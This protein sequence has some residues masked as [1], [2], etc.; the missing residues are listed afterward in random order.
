MK[1]GTNLLIVLIIQ[2]CLLSNHSSAQ[3]NT[4]LLKSE[5]SHGIPEYGFNVES[6]TKPSWDD[7]AFSEAITKLAPKMLRF[8]GGT[9]SQYFDWKTGLVITQKERDEKNLRDYREYTLENRPNMELNSLLSLKSAVDRLNFTPIFCLNVISRSLE[10]QLEMLREARSLGLP[11]DYIELGNEV[12]ESKGDFERKYPTAKDYTDTMKIWVTTLRREFPSAKFGVIGV[13]DK[14]DDRSRTWNDVMVAELTNTVDAITLHLYQGTGV[15]NSYELGEIPVALSNPFRKMISL[16]KRISELPSNWNVWI[17]E[18]NLFDLNGPVA[19]T[20]SHGLYTGLM[21][22]LYFESSKVTVLL[23]HQVKGNPSFRSLRGRDQRLT[24]EGAAEQLINQAMLGQKTATKIDFSDNPD[25]YS[26]TFS[27]QAL[28]GWT[29]EGADQNTAVLINAS[30]ND[31]VVDATNITSSFYADQKF[32]PKELMIQPKE[33]N[34][35]SVLKTQGRDQLTLKPYSITVIYYYPKDEFYVVNPTSNL[36]IRTNS[37]GALKMKD[38][39]FTGTNQHWTRL[40][41]GINTFQL[42]NIGRARIIKAISEQ[43]V[44]TTDLTDTSEKTIWKSIQTNNN[45]LFLENTFTSKRIHSSCN[46]G[47][48]DLRL[49]DSTY[50]DRCVQWIFKPV[51]TN[52]NSYTIKINDNPKTSYSYYP[53]PF[54]NELKIE[55]ISLLQEIL[56]ISLTGDII[57]DSKVEINQKEL[58]WNTSHLSPGVYFVKTLNKNGVSKTYKVLKK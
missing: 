4:T 45:S 24:A 36:R 52:R 28:T 12:Y 13:V 57:I 27:Y 42:K 47:T 40:S 22:L 49:K 32:M 56:L 48:E 1:K 8:P 51:E 18:Y 17:T 31:V 55:D 21:K 41:T 43:E 11:I 34:E 15:G 30:V 25:I 3:I 50:T 10:N 38:D 39:S 6:D 14:K 33:G 29:F 35:I 46:S 9:L 5:I 19:E 26:G 53:N 58:L 23:N 44:T 37:R 7:P 54:E 20:W 16:T 2:L